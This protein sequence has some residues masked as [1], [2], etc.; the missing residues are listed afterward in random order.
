MRR[1]SISFIVILLFSSCILNKERLLDKYLESASSQLEEYNYSEAINN[2]QNYLAIATELEIKDAHAEVYRSLGTCFFKTGN[3]NEALDALY[4][5]HDYWKNTENLNEQL[6]TL[7]LITDVYLHQKKIKTTNELLITIENLA[8][9]I[10]NKNAQTRANICRLNYQH[11][12]FKQYEQPLLSKTQELIKHTKD[13]LLIQ[14]LNIILL[15]NYISNWEFEKA[16]KLLAKCNRQK[17]IDDQYKFG[18]MIA[19]TELLLEQKDN[20]NL[21]DHM[22][23]FELF[24][25]SAS[26]PSYQRKY[27]E[28]E[29]IL[30]LQQDDYSKA[31]VKATNLSKIYK[32]E[33]DT[34]GHADAVILKLYS[35]AL[36]GD[37]DKAIEEAESLLAQN[38]E[39]DYSYGYYILQR[40]IAHNLQDQKQTDQ[41]LELYE[42]IIE[43]TQNTLLSNI[44]FYA[45]AYILEINSGNGNFEEANRRL[46]ILEKVDKTNHHKYAFNTKKGAIQFGLKDYEE[47]KKCFDQNLILALS[48]GY[49]HGTATTMYNLSHFYRILKQEALYIDLVEETINY[50]EENQKLNALS[51]IYYGLGKYYKSKK[52]IHNCN[53]YWLKSIELKEQ[54]RK[55]AE[56]EARKIYMESEIGIYNL[57]Q[58]NYF[59]MNALDTCYSIGELSKSKWL[60]EQ[61]SGNDSEMEFPK[62]ESITEN[63]PDDMILLTYTNQLYLKTLCL[64]IDHNG[65]TGNREENE[66]VFKSMLEDEAFRSYLKKH[67]EEKKYTKLIGIEKDFSTAVS[68]LLYVNIISYYR[69]LLQIPLPTKQQK[70]QTEKVANLLYQFLIKPFSEKLTNKQQL[71]IIPDAVLGYLPFETLIDDEGNYLIESFDIKYVQSISVWDYLN[72]REYTEEKNEILAL[73]NPNYKNDDHRKNGSVQSLRTLGL[74]LS[75]DSINNLLQ[76][77]SWSHLPGSEYEL[78]QIKEIYPDGIFIEWNDVTESKIKE[79]SVSNDLADYRI[80]HFST[81]GIFVKHHPE[82]SAIVFPEDHEQDGFLNVHEISK[83]NIESD[84][85]NLSGCETGMGDAYSGEG[86]VGLAQSFI[87]SGA[88]GLSVSLWQVP[89]RSTA[90]FMAIFY[91]KVKNKEMHYSAA[92]NKTKRQFINNKENPVLAAPYYWA[93][94]IYYGK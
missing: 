88:N 70:V 38:L 56:P 10:D 89:D 47:A 11:L 20:S 61:I 50:F 87:I 23:E 92:I 19:E 77:I 4:K 45:H 34:V 52:D 84:F 71:V 69:E 66:K 15:N 82:L 25:K 73:G 85:V 44:A 49:D 93:S 46:E 16:S 40:R 57:I 86:L 54:I 80:L 78:K 29:I 36:L 33:K 31:I 59:N 94:F 67:L 62:L 22:H 8:K 48:I 12:K 81:H 27:S 68:E 76:D 17:T 28:F 32:N 55:T 9:N 1:L 6:I 43:A 79:L 37:F 13:S 7:E 26:D 75:T 35:M 39:A 72:K 65:I 2:F 3:T 41:A 18:L 91:S 58:Q 83:L 64:Q 51:D 42:S 63:I 60:E 74:N 90:D 5:A 24:V 14:K 21:L 53:K 30:H